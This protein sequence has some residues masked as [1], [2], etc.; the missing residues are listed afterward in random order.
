MLL[1]SNFIKIPVSLAVIIPLFAG[2]LAM[3]IYDIFNSAYFGFNQKHA[4]A[5]GWIS[6]AWGIWIA[7][8][9][10]T[11]GASL[12]SERE[13]VCLV[14]GISLTLIGSMELYQLHRERKADD[15]Q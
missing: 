9:P 15:N 2:L 10:L 6:V 8:N 3:S 7:L 11:E 4:K 1:L 14:I 12:V 13:I 5:D